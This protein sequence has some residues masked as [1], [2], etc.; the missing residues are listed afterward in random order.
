MVSNHESDIT[1]VELAD[2]TLPRSTILESG[3]PVSSNKPVTPELSPVK[4]EDLT[5]VPETMDE[6][7]LDAES[8]MVKVSVN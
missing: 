3:N 1:G 2:L 7:V 5:L 8:S 6:E 4:E